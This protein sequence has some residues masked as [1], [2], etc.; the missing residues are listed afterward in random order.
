[1]SERNLEYVTESE[2]EES[3]VEELEEESEEEELLGKQKA[4]LSPEP[5]KKKICLRPST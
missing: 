2:V 1:M 5:E 3:E 4:S